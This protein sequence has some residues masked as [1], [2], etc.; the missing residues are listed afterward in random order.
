MCYELTEI[1][2]KATEL[3]ELETALA[4]E[5]KSKGPR[6]VKETINIDGTV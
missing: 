5:S 4:A 6:N 1:F 3:K 2:L